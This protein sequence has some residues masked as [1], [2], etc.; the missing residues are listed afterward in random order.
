MAEIKSTLELA[1]ERS[2]RYTLSKKEKEEIKQ[3]E[4]QEKASSLFYRYEEDRLSLNDLQRE[5][6][7]MEEGIRKPVEEALL[8]RWVE[9]LSLSGENEKIL[10]G[11]EWLR[12]QPIDE[13]REPLQ[14]LVGQYQREKDR[15][16]QDVRSQLLEDLRKEGF[17][18]DA[19]E[20]NVEMSKVW[21]EALSTF[22][23]EYQLKLKKI[24]E[25]LTRL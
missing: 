20:P 25:R 13:V 4:I 22:D 12:Q 16:R 11:M 21:K 10:R 15:L 5:I 23:Q 14:K 17:G 1:L 9:A 3:K 7:R 18:G 24:K 6:E 2:K 19:I 8:K